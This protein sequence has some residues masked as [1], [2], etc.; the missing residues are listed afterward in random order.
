VEDYVS[1][2]NPVEWSLITLA[3]NLK[4]AL[5]L[6]TVEKLIAAVS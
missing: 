4:R 3:Y 1:A 6:V 5:N 2:A